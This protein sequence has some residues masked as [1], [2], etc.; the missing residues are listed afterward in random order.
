MKRKHTPMI[1]TLLSAIVG[2]FL[3]TVAIS[4][5]AV[6]TQNIPI[7]ITATV[8]IPPCTLNGGQLLT[9]DFK[10]VQTRYVN[11]N[12]SES[13]RS[14]TTSVPIVCPSA[15][16]NSNALKVTM[17]GAASNAGTYILNTNG[18]TGAG[19]ALYQKDNTTAPLILNKTLPLSDLGSV[20]GNTDDGY[21]GSLSFTAV[22]VKGSAGVDV[23][24]GV[25]SAAA[26]LLLNQ[27]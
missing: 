5:H 1:H 19:I 17:R 26:T 11:R 13:K 20:I 15:V 3:L 9:V 22:L 4:V 27:A 24:E 16:S 8:V 2:S 14:V 7:T 23:K 21:Q 18:G 10:E 12:I 6:D 25:F